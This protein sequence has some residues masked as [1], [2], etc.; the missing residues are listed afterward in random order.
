MFGLDDVN[1]SSCA[2]VGNSG[3]VL[4]STHGEFI[5]SHDTVIRF[6]DA[7]VEGYEKSVGSRT[8]IRIVNCHIFQGLINPD[9]YKKYFSNFDPEFPLKLHNEI[10]LIKN[11]VDPYAFEYVFHIMKDNGCE[12][13]YLD[14]QIL[15]TITKE[16]HLPE[17]EPSNGVVGIFLGSKNFKTTSC[18]G[19]SFYEEPWERK[20]Y[21]E[22][23][24][25]YDQ[26]SHDFT[27]EKLYVTR[28]EE[29]GAIKIYK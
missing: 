15:T 3:M 13:H 27:L 10:I 25:P 18:F 6:N 1:L 21:Y 23:I 7:V 5:D 28:L 2:V 26:A 14:P 22:E 19:F 12:I 20:H 8:D 24:T 17:G 4:D 11:N 9:Y 29:E 16:L